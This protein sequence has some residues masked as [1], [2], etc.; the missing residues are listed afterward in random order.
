MNIESQVV[1]LEL[2][3]RLHELGVRVES[4]FVLARYINL[5]NQL[6]DN[7]IRREEIYKY[8][9][10]VSGILNVYTTAELGEILKNIWFSTCFVPAESLW[11]G[12]FFDCEERARDYKPAI[13]GNTEADCRA[14][15]LIYCIEQGLIKIKDY[16]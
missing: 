5:A 1:N 12:D 16:Q 6:G 2:S 7:I 10:D 8:C 11:R 3:K 9:P 14:K 13:W 15:A 4:Y